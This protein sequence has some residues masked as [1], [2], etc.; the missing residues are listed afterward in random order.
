MHRYVVVGLALGACVSKDF[1]LPG[2]V[3]STT[4]L[5]SWPPHDAIDVPIDTRIVL[6]WDGTG[7]PLPVDVRL[8]NLDSE[9][10]IHE[11]PGVLPPD[12]NIGFVD[13]PDLLEPDHSYGLAWR[14]GQEPFP[15][16]VPEVP[17]GGFATV[18]YAAFTTGADLAK[19]A[20]NAVEILAVDPTN[21][22]SLGRSTVFANATV[23]DAALSTGIYWEI[24][25]DEDRLFHAG[26]AGVRLMRATH[27][28]VTESRPEPDLCISAR[29]FS[30]AGEPGAESDTI[31]TALDGPT[32]CHS[33]AS[34]VNGWWLVA[35]PI[36]LGIRR[37][38]PTFSSSVP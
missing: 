35:L 13:L 3:P 38:K 19:A 30:A 20:D 6:W 2:P 8:T 9:E 32:A 16:E 21:I 14:T 7:A 23:D 27:S 24:R 28:A 22:R 25:D 11:E 5:E 31:C 4:P 15:T 12:G 36:I 29:S 34:P 26:V 33:A 37:R 10:I 1:S 17:G 18:S